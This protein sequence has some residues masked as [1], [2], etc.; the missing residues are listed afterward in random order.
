MTLE[1]Q[2][3]S[4]VNVVDGKDGTNGK[5][6]VAGKDGVGIVSTTISYTQSTSGT[7]TPTSGWQTQVPTLVKGQYLWT[8]TVWTYSDS[9]SETGYSVSYNAKD[10][11]N[12]ND[13]IAGKDG[14]GIKNTIVEY[15]SSTSGTVKPTSGWQTQVPTVAAGNYLW[16]RTTWQY[17]DNT[18][19]QGYSVTRFGVNGT[20]GKDG[21]NGVSVIGSQIE[22]TLS[23]NG[24]TIPTTGWQSTLPVLTPGQ[25]LWTRSRNALSNGTFT[26]WAYSVS[27]VGRDAILIQDVAPT[28]PTVGM[29]WQKPNDPTVLKWN[30]TA[31]IEWGI[32]A[33][34]IVADNLTVE[35]GRFKKL[36]GTEIEGGIIR[37]PYVRLY[38]D[39][40]TARG[41]ITL[42]DSE[43]NNVGYIF[44]S[45]NGSYRNY[46]QTLSHQFLSMSMY[47]GQTGQGANQLI[48]SVGIT[49]DTLSMTDAV[50]GYSGTL[51]AQQLT[52]VPWTNI[53]LNSGYEVA[54][55]STPQYR[56]VQNIDGS[57]SVELRGRIK[58]VSGNFSTVGV[59]VA[60]LPYK[61]QQL[62]GFMCLGNGGRTI[63]IQSELNGDLSVL[64][65]DSASYI[66]LSGIRYA[67]N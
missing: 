14:V 32:A 46:V 29:L 63:R 2:P 15:T 38:N 53:P 22:Y 23:S 21:T 37:N 9:T 26:N 52:K 61:P 62:E 1:S 41:T 54:E 24:Q 17:T 58:P 18:S 27:L 43:Y 16:T 35:N 50:N 66:S 51:T 56:R 4:I 5:D 25:Y 12:G 13:G 36:E 49:Y 33:A 45:T 10:G 48:S 8:R 40:T 6:G 11:N 20:N 57:Y 64:T 47:S 60:T 3:L 34:N 39:N 67:T 44:N 28:N 59:T 31:W 55:G 30:G 42:A 65:M 19:E 7:V